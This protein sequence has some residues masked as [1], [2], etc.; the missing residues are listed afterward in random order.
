MAK[1]V[2]M[3]V[4]TLQQVTVPLNEHTSTIQTSNNDIKYNS[5]FWYFKL[6]KK[7][8]VFID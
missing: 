6:F 3:T 7:Y 2:A 5:H 4:L 1:N 8:F